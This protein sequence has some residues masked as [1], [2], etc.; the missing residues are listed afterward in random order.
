[1]GILD[2]F[3]STNSLQQEK[4]KTEEPN[5]NMYAEL[6]IIEPFTLLVGGQFNSFIGELA[7][8][9]FGILNETEKK[10]FDVLW[11]VACIDIDGFGNNIW[12]LKK[13]SFEVYNEKGVIVR[14]EKKSSEVR[15]KYG[16]E[17]GRANFAYLSKDGNFIIS[18]SD[19]NKKAFL[20]YV[21]EN[22]S[23]RL[24]KS[25]RNAEAEALGIETENVISNTRVGIPKTISIPSITEETSKNIDTKYGINDTQSDNIGLS[26]GGVKR[27]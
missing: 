18:Q 14:F 2:K 11:K 24:L 8:N 6:G 5:K 26:D 7:D 22:I 20:V 21:S 15:D 3:K 16:S 25:L 1:M 13:G 4:S 9:K 27:R 19:R 12:N 23:D 17:E 10:A